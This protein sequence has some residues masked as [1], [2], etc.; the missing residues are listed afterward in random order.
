MARRR[1]VLTNDDGIDEPG[2]AALA[3][4]CAALGEVVVVAPVD[5]HSGVSHRVTEAELAVEERG[6]GWYA[7]AGTPADCTRVALHAICPDADWV[8]AGINAG[9]NVGVDVYVSGTVAAAREA[10]IHGRPSLA[11]SQ[12]VRRY[13][14]IDWRRTERAAAPVLR[15]ALE[16]GAAPGE[17]WNANLPDPT[18]PEGTAAAIRAGEI[19]EC[20]VDTS[21]SPVGFERTSRGVAWRAD[22]HARPRRAHHD[23]DVC[24][25]G[26]IALTRLRIA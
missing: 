21:P 25:G 18:G 17:Y 6:G 10:A 22:Y 12:Y 7:V 9:A 4:A 11:I 1:I 5:A 13:G 14:A 26:R 8:V 24:F 20:P 16:L 3:R 2:L 19:V 23:I 15:R